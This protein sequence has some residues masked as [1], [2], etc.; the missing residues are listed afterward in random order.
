MTSIVQDFEQQTSPYRRELLAHCYQMLGSVHD[1]EDLVQET[2]LR[3]WR[4]RGQFDDRRAS[5]RTWLYRIATNACLTALQARSRRPLPAGLGSPGDDPMQPFNPGHDVPWLEPLPDALVG[6]AGR[7]DPASILLARGT[8]R[9]ALV[10]AMQ[11]LPPRQ[12]AVLILRDVLDLPAADVADMLGSTTAAVNSA[13]QRARARLSEAGVDQ[14]QVDEPADPARQLLVDR[15]VAA[16]QHADV[17]ALKRLLTDDAVLEMPPML[18]W[19]AGREAYAGFIDRVFAMRGPD[20]RMLPV[21]AN[22][23][24]AVIAYVRGD[25]GDYHIHSLQVFTAGAG[26][27]SHNVVFADPAAFARFTLASRLPA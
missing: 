18:N 16:F 8:L 24:P 6:R 13:L 22:G 19:F 26:G 3:A 10:A 27:I 2:L 4:A 25:D 5:L 9:L 12:R 11:L 21:A 23:Q 20:W 14:D 17:A 7:D 1:A 15:Y